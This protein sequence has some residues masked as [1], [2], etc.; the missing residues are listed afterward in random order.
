MSVELNV[1]RDDQTQEFGISLAV[2]SQ[3]KEWSEHIK[4]KQKAF[5]TMK[6]GKTMTNRRSSLSQ[7]CMLDI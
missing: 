3:R 7:F 2:H 6:E 4:A 1:I 5:Y